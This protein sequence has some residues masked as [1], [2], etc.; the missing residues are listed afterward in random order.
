[1][2]TVYAPEGISQEALR[3]HMLDIRDS[4]LLAAPGAQVELLEVFSA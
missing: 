4:V 3:L 1:L 2:F